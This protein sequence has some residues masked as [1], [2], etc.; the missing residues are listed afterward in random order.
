MTEQ[1]SAITPNDVLC[2]RGGATN[3]HRGNKVFRAIV[4]EY[5][6]QYLAAKKKDKVGIAK[7]VVARIHESG[8]RFL[9]HD[10]DSGAW[11]EVPA[12]KAV[13]KTSQALREGLDVKH[14]TYRPAKMFHQPGDEIRAPDEENNPRKRTRVVRGTV[15]RAAGVGRPGSGENIP[16]L[17]DEYLAA[18]LGAHH[19]YGQYGR[20]RYGQNGYGQY[21]VYGQFG[22]FP[23]R[24]PHF[25]PMEAAVPRSDVD[26]VAAV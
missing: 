5:Q 10:G 6:A 24:F 21:G 17:N 23:G 16:D 15:S 7:A 22:P 14:K 26:D 8:G 3:N 9:K 11:V 12:R 20:Y 2:G 18:A 19:Q 25:P 1:D 4:S 13:A